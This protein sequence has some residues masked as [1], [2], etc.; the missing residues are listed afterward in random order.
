MTGA[1]AGREVGLYLDTFRSIAVG[2]FLVTPTGRTY[3]LT[4]VRRQAR[5]KHAG[6]W[7][8]HAVV[9]DPAVP[10]VDDVV[11]RMAWYRRPRKTRT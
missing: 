3:H 11:H 9:V 10:G 7:H 1:P 8:I 5:G 2:D 4:T 6:R